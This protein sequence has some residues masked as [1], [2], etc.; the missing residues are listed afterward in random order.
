MLSKNIKI[1]VA[2]IVA[3]F[4]LSSFVTNE[5]KENGEIKWITIQEALELSKKDN[6]PIFVDVYTDWCGWCKVMDK[7]TFSDT[8][9][10]SYVGENYYAVKL[11]PEKEGTIVYQG[12]NYTNAAFANHFQIQGYPTILLLQAEK[13]S[14][15]VP[16]FQDAD[17]FLKTLEKF[18]KTLK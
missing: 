18:K 15:A 10:S 2:V 14:K 12:K 1:A 7:K 13:E 8:D 4:T 3:L 17:N 11:N 6:K 16:G 9:V 5:P